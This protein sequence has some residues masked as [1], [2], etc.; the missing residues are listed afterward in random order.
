MNTRLQEP[1]RHVPITL[2][3]PVLFGGTVNQI[4][5]F[6]F[7]FGMIFFWAF[8]LR[9]DL[10]MLTFRGEIAQ[11]PGI[12]TGSEKTNA[13]EGGTEH[14]DG[15]PIYANYFRYEAGGV[16][17]ESVSY[18]TGRRLSTG[19]QINVEYLL[20][21][22][23]TARISGMRQNLFGPFAV[24]V[25]IFPVIGLAF[26]FPGLLK[27]IK[28]LRLLRG[29]IGTTGKLKSKIA[30]SVRINERPVFR[31][32]FEFNTR[33]GRQVAMTVKTHTP[34]LLEDDEQERILYDAHNPNYAITL[35]HLPG[36]PEIDAFGRLRGR[37][38]LK[39]LATL[40]I[41]LVTITGHGGYFYFQFMQ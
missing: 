2:R 14:S 11:T 38:F 19:Q 26:I 20:A 10:S 4:G 21:A 5:W 12:V 8:A 33:E 6:F 3:L 30:T 34:E 15:T 9:A 22:P 16:Q 36:N 29:G 37:G 31:M 23:K 18:A 35:D 28:A 41:P 13:S 39:T 17:Y 25:V 24:F 1:P 32:R 40:F 7:G 27:G